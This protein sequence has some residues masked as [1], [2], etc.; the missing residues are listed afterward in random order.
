MDCRT[1]DRGS[2]LMIFSKTRYGSQALRKTCICMFNTGRCLTGA[3]RKAFKNLMGYMSCADGRRH[4]VRSL[5]ANSYG[6]KGESTFKGV[7]ETS[8]LTLYQGCQI[9]E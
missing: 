7:G 9:H 8:E 4:Q 3:L 2:S 6:V 5:D 1:V